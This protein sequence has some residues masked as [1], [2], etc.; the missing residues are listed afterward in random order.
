MFPIR[1][2]VPTRYPP[3]ITWTLIGLNCTIF[4]FQIALSPDELELFLVNFALIPAR[5]FAPLALGLPEPGLSDYLPFV[6]NMFLHGGLLH[7]IVN[8]WTL[9]LF[10]PVVEDRLG[11]GRYL[12]FYLLCGAVASLAHAAFNPTSIVPALGAS[13]AIAGVMGC[14]VRWFPYARI[15][16][17]V[18]I[19]FLPLFF[20]VHALFYVGFWFL[21][22]IM[23][24][25]AELFSPST[26]GG[27]VAWWAHIGGFIAGLALASV[28]TPSRSSYRPYYADEG[29]YGFTPG[30][31][32]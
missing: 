19:L 11:S 6:T 29:I 10:G 21:M 9:W 17:L 4:F 25:S 15:I 27:G 30:G 16:I 3:T 32:R 12:V 23:Q 22:Q 5:Y 8:M 20:E 2:S 24:G 1:N 31:Y 26:T 28:L 14:Y 18:P 13:G 7:L